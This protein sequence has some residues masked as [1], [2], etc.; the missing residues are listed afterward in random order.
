MGGGS[1]ALTC[2]YS[3]TLTGYS[4]T[5]FAQKAQPG[6]ALLVRAGTDPKLIQAVL[7]DMQG[8]IAT[9]IGLKV[10]SG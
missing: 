2:A 8:L 1:S 4:V 5:V 9:G 3:L 7:R 6:G 10:I